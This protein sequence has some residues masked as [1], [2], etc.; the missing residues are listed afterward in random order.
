MLFFKSEFCQRKPKNQ[1]NVEFFQTSSTSPSG[2]RHQLNIH[3]AG[4]APVVQHE[5]AESQQPLLRKVN[6]LTLP[7]VIK[8]FAVP[9]HPQQALADRLGAGIEDQCLHRNPSE[10]YCIFYQSLFYDFFQRVSIFNFPIS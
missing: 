5:R 6:A 8:C 4:H 1:C 10:K 2:S 7:S 3:F 9:A